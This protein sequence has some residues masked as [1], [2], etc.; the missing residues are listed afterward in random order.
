MLQPGRASFCSA[1]YVTMLHDSSIHPFF[2]SF[3]CSLT[4]PC[5]RYLAH[6]N[7]QPCVHS[8]CFEVFCLTTARNCASMSACSRVRFSQNAVL[9]KQHGFMHCKCVGQANYT[10]CYQLHSCT[11]PKCKHLKAPFEQMQNHKGAV[12]PWSDSLSCISYLLNNFLQS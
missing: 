4:R 1:P 5:I 3:T 6:L 11:T 10:T 9:N 2:Q 7:T 8:S 12:L